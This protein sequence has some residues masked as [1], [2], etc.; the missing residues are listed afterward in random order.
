MAAKA[1]PKKNGAVVKEEAASGFSLGQIKKFLDE[2]KVE[3]S[4]IVW[5]ERKVTLTLTIVVII[6]S[7]LVAAYLGTVDLVLGKVVS[8]ILK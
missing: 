2:V 5:P 4:K 8:T 3:F 6:V 1:K 7:L